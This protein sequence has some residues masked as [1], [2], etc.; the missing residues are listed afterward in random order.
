[1]K[2]NIVFEISQEN[3]ITKENR[4]SF[5]DKAYSNMIMYVI[6]GLCPSFL[7]QVKI[8]DICE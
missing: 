2:A 6:Q 5:S 8:G 3:G 4:C 7:N 1:M